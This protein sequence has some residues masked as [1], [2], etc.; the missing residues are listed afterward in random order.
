[1]AV[2][3]DNSQ[4][5]PKATVRFISGTVQFMT[6]LNRNVQHETFSPTETVGSRTVAWPAL[7][8]QTN[9]KSF[10]H[11]H[12]LIQQNRRVLPQFSSD[13]MFER[14]LLL[15]AINSR[16]FKLRTARVRGT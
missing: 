12:Y 2:L 10:T 9:S 4:L 15:H 7:Q 1:M 5:L 6:T 3:H 8:E 13:A 16:C 14:V 11:V